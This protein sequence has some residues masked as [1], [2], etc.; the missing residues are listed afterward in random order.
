[1]KK[2]EDIK[3]E[4]AETSSKYE[5]IHYELDKEEFIEPLKGKI[6]ELREKLN[7][8]VE[9]EGRRGSILKKLRISGE[10]HFI[11]SLITQIFN[12]LIPYLVDLSSK[13]S[14]ISELHRKLYMNLVPLIDAKDREWF[15]NATKELESKEEKFQE[16]VDALSS[17]V[18]AA[19]EISLAKGQG[20][21][22]LKSSFYS[23]FERRFRTGEIKEGFRVYLPYL[24]GNQPVLDFGCGSGEMLELLRDDEVEAFGVDINR[25]FIDECKSKE[26]KCF[27][28]DGIKFLNSLEDSSLGA[29]FSA[30]VL[31]HFPV[32][33][34]EKIVNISWKKVKP[35][36]I[37]IA[38]TV[39]VASP[40]AFHGAFLLDPTHITPL[41]PQTL[42]FI[43]QTNGWKVEEI[44]RKNLPEQLMEFPAHNEREA[45]IR[46]SLRKINGFLFSHQ[47]YAVVGRKP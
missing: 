10:Q 5:K 31:E 24:K 6:E 16:Y 2:P 20:E 34:V 21:D 36:G 12:L 1:M 47:D 8:S 27:R 15:S 7:V 4:R 17:L 18:N 43:L 44:L 25:E 42:S 39:N 9:G 14:R 41:H 38:E 23:W 30:Q 19:K 33:D 32:N 28:E 37:F 3:R 11:N 29:V 35:G 40:S 22:N 46:E 45:A 26:L 13:L